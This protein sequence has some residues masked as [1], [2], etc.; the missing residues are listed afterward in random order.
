MIHVPTYYEGD[1]V[2]MNYTTRVSY[3]TCLQFKLH[4]SNILQFAQANI[5]DL[6]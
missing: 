6:F 4:V 1:F 5:S 2:K 3:S